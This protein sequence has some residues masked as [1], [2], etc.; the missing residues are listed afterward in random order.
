VVS[1]QHDELIAVGRK[2]RVRRTEKCRDVL[3]KER[4]EEG[5]GLLLIVGGEHSYRQ[6]KRRPGV[7]Q[8]LGICFGIPPRS[9]R[10]SIPTRQRTTRRAMMASNLK[11]VGVAAATAIVASLA[12]FSA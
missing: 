8:A 12:N 7:S 3:A 2:Q 11:A 4:R 10:W 6:T 9:R 5:V 1:G